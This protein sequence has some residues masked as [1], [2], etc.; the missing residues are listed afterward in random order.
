LIG[1]SLEAE[2]RIS[3]PDAVFA[4]LERLAAELRYL[5]IVSA[6]KLER[7]GAGNGSSGMRVEVAKA[8]GQKCERCW[9]YSP[10]VGENP[11]Y[12]TICERCTAALEEGGWTTAVKRAQ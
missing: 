10:R 11:G 12:P 2:V 1:S 3:A 9:N 4:I 6:V 7:G 8:P 5:F